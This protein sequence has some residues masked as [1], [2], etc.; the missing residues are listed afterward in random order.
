[1]AGL[2]AIWMI[3]FCYIPIYGLIIAFKEYNILKPISASRWVGFSHFIEFFQD[4]NFLQIMT[5]TF[6]ISLLRLFVGFTLPIIFAL[7]LSEL[8][9]RKLK[10]TVQTISY[11]PHFL[12]WVVLGG[13][14]MNW[15]SDM[16]MFN[17]LLMKLGLLK[18][19]ITFLAE[20]KYFWAIVITSDIWKELG[21]GAIIYLAAIS[22]VDSAIYEAAKVDGAGR[23]RRIW[24]IVL[25]SIRGTIAVLLILSVGYLMNTNFDQILVLMNQLNLERSNVLD[26]FVYRTGL[27][28]GRFSYATAIGLFRS[29]VAM[30]LLFIANTATKKLTEQSLW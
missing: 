1:M 16:G 28:N 6:G 15:L 29:L 26:I 3:I 25:P 5:N 11:L 23:F 19:P 13:L 4:E 8:T 12:S 17:A 7:L 9:S 27:Q 10:R 2:G 18:E 21:W 30:V 20:P 22:G 14:M 24:S